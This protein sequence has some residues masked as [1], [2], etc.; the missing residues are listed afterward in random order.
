MAKRTFPSVTVATVAEKAGV[1]RS[2][3]GFILSGQAEKRGISE[4]TAQRVIEVAN[5]LNFVPNQ[6]ARALRS[7][8]SGVIGVLFDHLQHEWAERVMSS[9][10]P[11]LA[12]EGYTSLLATHQY[13]PELQEREVQ[14]FLGSRVEAIIFARFLE[15]SDRSRSL[16]DGVA[17]RNT[18][19]VFV[20]DAPRNFPQTSRVS[21]ALGQAA[22]AAVNHLIETGRRRIAFLSWEPPRLPMTKARFRGYQEALTG[23]SLEVD[24]RW[25]AWVGPER[26]TVEAV[27]RIFA[28]SERR[29]DALFSTH[30]ET[31][32]EA[33]G[34]LGELGLR[35]PG[36]VAVIGMGDLP[37]SRHPWV[38]MSTIAPP[39]EEIGREAARA[40]VSLIQEPDAEP[41]N[42][43]IVCNKVEK[44]KTTEP[45][46][47]QIAQFQI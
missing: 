27:R 12:A 29:P 2:T 14:S 10:R 25:V 16:L 43:M 22:R 38:S 32:L 13:D 33:L 34:A 28:D 19:M 5:R 31:A 23:A 45:M 35:V 40:V 9:I 17:R 8:R 15:S 47:I 36:D 30:D 41:I 46:E 3:A 39:A 24:E 7:Q 20:G 21:W 44:R 18:P 1:A 37:T 6:L 4:P 11:A 42:R 26:S